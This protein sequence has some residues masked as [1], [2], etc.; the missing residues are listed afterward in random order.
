MLDVLAHFARGYFTRLTYFF[1]LIP[2]RTL[3]HYHQ[4]LQSELLSQTT[5]VFRTEPLHFS[6]GFWEIFIRI[7]RQWMLLPSTAIYSQ[8]R[9]VGK[10]QG[11]KFTSMRMGL[12]NSSSPGS[13][14]SL[15]RRSWVTN[16]RDKKCRMHPV[17]RAGLLSVFPMLVT[18][19]MGEYRLAETGRLLVVCFCL[20]KKI[21]SHEWL[22]V[23]QSLYNKKPQ[24]LYFSW[25]RGRGR[26]GGMK[27]T[28]CATL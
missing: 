6:R 7:T 2:H 13:H 28:L 27:Q 18:S 10:I 24:S 9:L 14:G 17:F 26:Q 19:V 16:I 3:A 5:G 1:H 12:T 8:N 20:V 15:S 23:Y 25:G 11:P 22:V 4:L 21:S